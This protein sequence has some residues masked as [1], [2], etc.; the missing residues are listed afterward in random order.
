VPVQKD[1]VEFEVHDGTLSWTEGAT[2][3]LGRAPQM[4]QEFIRDCVEDYARERGCSR[5]CEDI[6]L[7][8][9]RNMMGDM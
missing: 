2:E 1:K 5:I 6:V 4:I 7:E 8:A 3:L 9:K